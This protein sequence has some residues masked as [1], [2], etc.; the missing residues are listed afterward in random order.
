M[1]WSG[2]LGLGL[3]L[4]ML[5]G[6]LVYFFLKG[7]GAATGDPQAVVIL[8]LAGTFISGLLVM[9]GL[10][11][12][13]AGFGLLVHKTWSRYLAVALGVL[14]LFYV[15]VGT[16]VGIY[17]VWVLIQEKAAMYFTQTSSGTAYLAGQR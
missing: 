6:A 9:L 1:K 8:G 16:L 17:T 10:P 5:I 3:V 11:S 7:V 13:V 15:P 14:N 12:V 2:G 4:S